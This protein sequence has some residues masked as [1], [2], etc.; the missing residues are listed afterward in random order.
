MA[1]SRVALRYAKATLEL[2]ME[3]KTAAS[4]ENDMRFILD[5]LNEN[6]LDLWAVHGF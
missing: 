2:A 1:D 5:T 6:R 3:S 4:I